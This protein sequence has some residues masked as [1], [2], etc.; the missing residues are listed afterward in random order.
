[1]K[2]ICKRIRFLE[3]TWTEFSKESGSC[4]KAERNFERSR[5]LL[6]ELGFPEKTSKEFAKEPASCKKAERNFERSR[7][8]GVIRML[9]RLFPSIGTAIRS[10]LRSRAL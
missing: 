10:F 8:L 5:V 6:K 3:K 7:L 1:M 2:G 9:C 4:K